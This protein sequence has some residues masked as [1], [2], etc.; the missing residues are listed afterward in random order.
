MQKWE[1]SIEEFQHPEFDTSSMQK[2]LDNWGRDG[3][4]LVSVIFISYTD[5]KLTRVFLKR[6]IT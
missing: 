1:Y 3:W 6:P 5:F 4:E 2:K